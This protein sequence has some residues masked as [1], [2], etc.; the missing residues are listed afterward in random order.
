[1]A[2]SGS[3]Q[4]M[5]SFEIF[6]GRTA[7]SYQD[8]PTSAII[9]LSCCTIWNCRLRQHRTESHLLFSGQPSRFRPSARDLALPREGFR[10][11]L[12]LA[13]PMPL[14]KRTDCGDAKYAGC[15]IDFSTDP[16]PY[17]QVVM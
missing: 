17:L 15:A 8:L 10:R 11:L 3:S 2:E 9:K 7:A 4:R 14:G 6:A 1:M 5:N 16:T 13:A 12:G